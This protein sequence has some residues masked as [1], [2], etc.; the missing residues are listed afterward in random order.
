MDDIFFYLIVF[1]TSGIFFLSLCNILFI[2][3]WLGHVLPYAIVI[4]SWAICIAI[5]YLM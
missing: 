3:L 4:G 5:K 1:F 2:S